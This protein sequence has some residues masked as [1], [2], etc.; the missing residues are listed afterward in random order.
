MKIRWRLS[1]LESLYIPGMMKESFLN[2]VS[3]ELGLEG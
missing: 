3:F 1:T 2:E